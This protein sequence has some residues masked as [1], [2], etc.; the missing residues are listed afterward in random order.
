[1][2]TVPDLRSRLLE[3]LEAMLQRTGMYGSTAGEV[4]TAFSLTLAD[5][6]FID[7]R[8][9]ESP[10]AHLDVSRPF[11][12]RGVAVIEEWF[13]TPEGLAGRR[14]YPRSPRSTPS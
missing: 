14:K 2:K 11:G 13:R 5:L 12:N 7:G 1:M 10:D 9:A 3:R 6:F 4:E 8:W